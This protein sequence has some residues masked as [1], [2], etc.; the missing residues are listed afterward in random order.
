MRVE[1]VSNVLM[2]KFIKI[3]GH[4]LTALVD[5]LKWMVFVKVHTYFNFHIF[6]PDY[7]VFML[8]AMKLLMPMMRTN[9][10]VN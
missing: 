4:V 10:R 1:N 3:F 6:Y 8:E 2:D 7:L 5:K 9:D